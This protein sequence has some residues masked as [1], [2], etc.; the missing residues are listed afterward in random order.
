MRLPALRSRSYDARVDG[1]PLR[2]GRITA[3]VVRVGETVRPPQQPNGQLV[4]VLLDRL[5]ELDLDLGPRYLGVDG[6][7][8]DTFSYLGGRFRPISTWAT[9]TMFWSRRR[10]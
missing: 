4:R 3:G 6:E 10:G 7:G 2:G 9:A 8:R 1:T 5:A